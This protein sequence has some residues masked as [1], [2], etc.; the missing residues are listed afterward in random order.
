MKPIVKIFVLL[1]LALIIR[2]EANSQ[3]AI[4]LIVSITGNV[5]D[6][7]TKQPI[8]VDIELLDETGSRVARAKSN[9]TDGYYFI[10]GLKPGKKYFL[11]NIVDIA[12]TKRYFRQKYEINIPQTDS[13][14]EYSRDLLFKPLGNGMEIPLRVSPFSYGKSVIRSGGELMLKRF[15]DDLKDNPRVKIDVSC[16][17]DNT[18]D[19]ASNMKL[20]EDRAKALKDFFVANGIPDSRLGI[21]ANKTIDTKVPPP[22]ER[23]PK[24]K[25]YK[26]SIYFVVT[27]Y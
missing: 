26:G 15:V 11:R 14:Q 16:F 20:T 18:S 1:I 21:Q 27:G 6:E 17:P 24:G 10:T 23:G 19:E 4:K 2:V 7:V 3:G 12:A 13:Y 22:I 8:G 25:Q 9:V 5:I